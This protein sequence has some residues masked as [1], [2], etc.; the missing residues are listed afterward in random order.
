MSSVDCVWVPAVDALPPPLPSS[1]PHAAA[2]SAAAATRLANV[3]RLKSRRHFALSITCTPPLIGCSP[4]DRS[5][6]VAKPPLAAV[7]GDGHEDDPAVDDEL[8]GLAGAVPDEDRD[9]HRDEH[10][11]DGGARVVAG[12]AEDRA[13]DDHRDDALEQVGV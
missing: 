12:P 8:H 2:V 3:G 11:A 13:A 7:D 9:E 1:L 4:R 6:A 10:R 5:D